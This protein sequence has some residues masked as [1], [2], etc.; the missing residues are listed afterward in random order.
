[1]STQSTTEEHLTATELRAKVGT[2]LFEGEDSTTP[3][4]HYI[5]VTEII[6]SV[7]TYLIN[8]ETDTLVGGIRVLLG[9]T[10]T[11]AYASNSSLVGGYYVGTNHPKGSEGIFLD[12][13][14]ASA[15]LNS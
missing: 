10:Q 8:K 13:I 15:F 3:E 2:I 5:I 9:E 11:V 1:M 4:N 7:A 14:K 6:G 12:I